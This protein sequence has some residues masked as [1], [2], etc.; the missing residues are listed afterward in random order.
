MNPSSLLQRIAALFT[1]GKYDEQF[2]AYVSET[3]SNLPQ[4]KRNIF[5]KHAK[6]AKQFCRTQGCHYD[7]LPKAVYEQFPISDLEK[8]LSLAF[9]DVDLVEKAK[10]HYQEGSE[11]FCV[12]YTLKRVDK[13]LA[14]LEPS[15]RDVYFDFE[16]S[17]LKGPWDR[18]NIFEHLV[19]DH[20]ILTLNQYLSFF[21]DPDYARFEKLYAL[22]ASKNREHKMWQGHPHSY[23]GALLKIMINH[24]T[25]GK[26]ISPW[27]CKHAAIAEAVDYTALFSV[28]LEN[29][30]LHEIVD[31]SNVPALTKFYQCFFRTEQRWSFGKYVIAVHNRGEDL[32]AWATKH[33]EKDPN[34]K[35][36]D[37]LNAVLKQ[38]HLCNN[39]NA[40]GDG[41]ALYEHIDKDSIGP[42]AEVFKNAKPESIL[43]LLYHG[44]KLQ[45][46]CIL[47]MQRVLLDEKDLK[48][49]AE[50]E[51]NDYK[52]RKNSD[53]Q[54]DEQLWN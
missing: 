11:Q 46:E 35:Y 13:M 26:S 38:D 36:T 49:W 42:L 6:K 20:K 23:T 51:L 27:V 25:A 10:E 3:A 39:P 16:T 44:R 53:V 41:T 7:I 31:E 50:T 47:N 30:E 48:V 54:V 32:I 18:T 34:G 12:A 19:E 33:Y 9:G 1:K 52:K 4:E 29:L 22:A 21:S 17:L 28:V 15:E 5:L 45:R 8:R 43:E 24:I 14:H 37:F 2:T 40:I